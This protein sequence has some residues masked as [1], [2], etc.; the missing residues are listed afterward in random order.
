LNQ[1]C[2]PIGQS[3]WAWPDSI[4]LTENR[5][6]IE[7]N[8][9]KDWAKTRAALLSPSERPGWD[10]VYSSKEPGFNRSGPEASRQWAGGMDCMTGMPDLMISPMGMDS[11]DFPNG[12]GYRRLHDRR[13]LPRWAWI[14]AISPMGEDSGDFPNGRRFRRFLQ[15]VRIQAI[16]HDRHGLLRWRGFRRFPRWA[17]IQAISPMGEDSGDSRDRRDSRDGHGFRQ[18]PRWAWIQAISPMGEDSP[19]GVDSGDS[20]R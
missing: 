10:G 14:Q 18:F 13:G 15:W 6:G 8:F 2:K 20:P 4:G 5:A 3:Q 9:V 16:P 11:G 19:M 7:P 1:G 17:W 12:W